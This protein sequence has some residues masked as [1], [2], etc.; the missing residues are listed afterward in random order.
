ML[1]LNWHSSINRERDRSWFELYPKILAYCL[2]YNP[3]FTSGEKLAEWWNLR[4]LISFEEVP[5]P[6][7]ELEFYVNSPRDYEGFSVKTYIPI[8]FKDVKLFV[9]DR[10]LGKEKILRENNVLLFFFDVLKG[11][12]K[13]KLMFKI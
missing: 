10:K 11:R 9:N 5:G 1:T 3:W 8:N 4:R 2:R 6:E 7:S 13:V 12:N